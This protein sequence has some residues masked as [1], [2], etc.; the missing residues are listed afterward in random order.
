MAD[1]NEYNGLFQYRSLGVN[2]EKLHKYMAH[3]ST[4]DNFF[5]HGP[6]VPYLLDL[7]TLMYAFICKSTINIL[8]FPNSH[9][10]NNGVKGLFDR[11]HPDDFSIL[12]YRVFPR[13]RKIASGKPT[14]QSDKLRFDFNYRFHHPNTKYIHCLEKVR[15]LET[16]SSGKPALVFGLISDITDHKKE[17]TIVASAS[18]LN[19]SDEYETVFFENFKLESRHLFTSRELQIVQLLDHGLS[20]KEIGMK[21]FI[22]SKT[23]DKHRRNILHKYSK[24]NTR[25]LIHH[26]RQHGWV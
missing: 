3:Y 10:L 14:S 16:D 18:I 17:N 13:F 8:G 6:S 19:K 15:I 7:S 4:M 2:P 23:V 25:E 9:F 26:A 21:L 22:S 1:Y 24:K 11:I 20:S 12:R 5:S